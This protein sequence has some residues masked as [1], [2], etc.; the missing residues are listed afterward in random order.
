ML[1]GR[2]PDFYVILFKGMETATSHGAGSIFQGRTPVSSYDAGQ[3]SAELIR[4]MG[5]SPSC[6]VVAI[7]YI[8]RIKA[9]LPGLQLTPTNV[10]RLLLVALRLAEKFLEDSRYR[11]HCWTKKVGVSSQE[12]IGLEWYVAGL[13]EWKM[14]VAR[15]EYDELLGEYYAKI[16]EEL[17]GRRSSSVTQI[18]PR[19]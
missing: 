1:A 14:A 7:I 6:A 13:L 18:L 8:K 3:Y 17:C 9:K 5:V 12:I 2:L 16:Q 19:A 15:A 10:K 11:I 4:W